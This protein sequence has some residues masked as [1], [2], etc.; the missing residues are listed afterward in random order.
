MR[1][2]FAPLLALVAVLASGCPE[3]MTVDSTARPAPLRYEAPRPN[4]PASTLVP[5]A[6]APRGQLIYVPVYSHIYV[7]DGRPYL[8]ESTLSLRN[9]DPKHPITINV[10]DYYDS[11]GRRLE[12]HL[13]A[14]LRLGPLES[15]AFLVPAPQTTGGAGANFLVEWVA[16]AATTPPIVECLMAGM[17]GAHGLSFARSGQVLEERP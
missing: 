6:E 16:E 5:L 1:V 14:P 8:L 13:D 11:E 9:T 3:P 2:L 4:R 15:T 10:V 7:A 17:S 12:R